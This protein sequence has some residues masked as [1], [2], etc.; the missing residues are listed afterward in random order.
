MADLRPL[1]SE[2]LDGIDKL[3]RIMEIARYNEKPKNEV[4]ENS[5]LNYTIE[6]A[7]GNTYGIVREK[8]GYII[9]KGLDESTI[10]YS[11]PIKHR[12]YHRSY[13]EAMKKLNLMAGEI[14][15]VY[16]NKEGISLIGEQP[17]VKKKF[18]L[19]QNK[20][21]SNVAP[22]PAPAPMDA[23]LAPPPP[24]PAMDDTIPPPADMATPPTGDLGATPDESAD[25]DPTMGDEPMPTGGEDVSLPTGD[26]EEPMPGMGDESEEEPMPGMGDESEDEE[27]GGASSL[28]TIQ[29]LTG[30]L[31]QKIRAFD[32]EKGLDSQDIKYV[33]NSIISAIDL[34]KLDDEDRDDILDKIEEY[35]EYDKDSETELN[36]DG[37]DDLSTD[38]LSDESGDETSM[39]LE[40]EGMSLDEP[41]GNPTDK[42]NTESKIEKVLSRYFDIKPEEKPII[43]ERKTRDF[44]KQKLDVIRYKGDIDM[45]S[46]TTK[47]KISANIVLKENKNAKLIGKTNKDNLI[48]SVGSRQIKVTPGGR[49]L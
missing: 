28:K 41:M 18:V 16:E 8:S 39:G 13:S 12:K 48:F 23:T 44:L 40:D 37:A 19:K 25:F 24:P 35:D 3:K 31:S 36:L 47:Q 32:K 30:R 34:A 29:K 15:R 27:T 14:N 1:G 4:N 46:E 49:I 43:E 20:P 22:A 45:M 6:L 17:E 42:L 10:D 21:K 38:D 5:T 2:K 33:M 7:D 9:K 11:E 26:D